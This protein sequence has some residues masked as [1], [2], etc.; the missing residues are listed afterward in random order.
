MRVL[1]THPD[2][3]GETIEDYALAFLAPHFEVCTFS[4]HVASVT[5]LLAMPGW[6]R[7]TYR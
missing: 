3:L 2:R 4:P 1:L 6:P 7:E 5:L